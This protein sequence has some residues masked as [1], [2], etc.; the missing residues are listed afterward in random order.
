MDR[1]IKEGVIKAEVYFEDDPSFAF[2]LLDG[3]TIGREGDMNVGGLP[4]GKYVSRVHATFL[5]EGDDWYIRDEGSKNFTYVNS[6]K[7]GPGG[8]VK[9]THEDLIT[10]GYMSFVFTLKD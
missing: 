3:L 6:V 5:K 8:K 1:A 7:V 9:L 2:P 10:L 4:G